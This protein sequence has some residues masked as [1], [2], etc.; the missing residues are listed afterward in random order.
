MSNA[1]KEQIEAALNKARDSEELRVVSMA[2]RSAYSVDGR[3]GARSG[4]S[5]GQGCTSTQA[6]VLSDTIPASSCA[7]YRCVSCNH[8]WTVVGLT[9]ISSL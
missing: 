2:C 8:T 5:Q 7:M 1:T 6:Y 3:P 9:G 4:D